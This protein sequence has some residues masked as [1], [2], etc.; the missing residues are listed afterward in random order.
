MLSSEF[1]TEF[2]EVVAKKPFKEHPVTPAW[3][4]HVLDTK[5]QTHLNQILERG[6]TRFDEPYPS[7]ESIPKL[8]PED[9]AILYCFYYMQFHFA[10]S[11]SLYRQKGEF[12]SSNMLL[13][14]KVIFIDFGCGPL[15]SGVALAEFYK[16]IREGEALD[17]NY[18]GID[19]SATMQAVACRIQEYPGL[20]ASSERFIYINK[21]QEATT[22]IE[23]M[24]ES[25]GK[26]FSIFLNMS[27]FMAAHGL[28]IEA[29]A[30]AI[31]QIVER[32]S[33]SPI[34]LAYQNPAS[35]ELNCNWQRLKCYLG[36]KLRSLKDAP[37]T[38]HVK[39]DDITGGWH[40]SHPIA[41][42]VYFDFLCNYHEESA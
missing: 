1:I 23:M 39:F 16:S 12:I 41:G 19:I 20:F 3:Q 8:T 15:T 26:D 29:L 6:R 27:Y 5:K 17:L 22:A 2:F 10:S 31:T 38:F 42:K 21:F 9:K 30:A 24:V 40:R 13:D 34:C 35:E 11:L 36:K 32:Y 33:D 18:V 14:K 37:G 4:Q 28:D 7:T 25:T